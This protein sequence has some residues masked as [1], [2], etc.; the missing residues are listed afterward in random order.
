MF[1]EWIMINYVLASA[2]AAIIVF[3]LS[4]LFIKRKVLAK[5]LPEMPGVPTGGEV[6][7]AI[8]KAPDEVMDTI[9][10]V[11]KE[12]EA[13]VDEID[14]D[15]LRERERKWYNKVKLQIENIK[16]SVEKGEFDKAK[17]NLN[18]AEL[19]MK[20]LELNTASD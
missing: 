15:T 1:L 14:I 8:K 2:A 7:T 11:V 19:F 17:R 3:S 12:L 18:D 4:F 10:A 13:K 6:V 16:K 5:E 20:M 9:T